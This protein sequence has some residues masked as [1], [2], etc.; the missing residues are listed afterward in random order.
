MIDEAAAATI[1]TMLGKGASMRDAA[2]A[3]GRNVSSV[4]RWV[5]KQNAA[6]RTVHTSKPKPKR[7]VPKRG[8][9][10]EAPRAAQPQCPPPPTA[11]PPP[12]APD[13]AGA[14]ASTGLTLHGLW[15][16]AHAPDTPAS[17]KVAA[18]RTH[19]EIAQEHARQP[20]AVELREALGELRA[21]LADPDAEPPAA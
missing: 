4:S 17:A 3:V 9:S 14:D 2:G 11:E 16:L 12:P 5:A 18:F 15:L 19:Y 21:D 20:S 6:G 1:R 7:A 8:A 13:V 10:I